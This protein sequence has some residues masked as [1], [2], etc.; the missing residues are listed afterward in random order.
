MVPSR[1]LRLALVVVVML[2]LP[3]GLA[4]AAPRMPIGFYDEIGRA[5]V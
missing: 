2:A 4:K 5:H 1:A 3:A